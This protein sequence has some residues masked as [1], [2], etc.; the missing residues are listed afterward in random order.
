M[1]SDPYRAARELQEANHKRR[2]ARRLAE[3]PPITEAER[4]ELQAR[5]FAD[6]HPSQ[7]WHD[8][9]PDPDAQNLRELAYEAR[10]GLA[11][12]PWSWKP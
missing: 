5:I 6:I 7:D 1:N 3:L 12:D 4:Q 2:E 10:Y 9:K 8:D 11:A